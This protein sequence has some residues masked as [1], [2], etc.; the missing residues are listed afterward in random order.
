MK[1]NIMTDDDFG[2]LNKDLDLI[3]EEEVKL[4]SSEGEIY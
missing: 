4:D 2:V 1:A 3:C